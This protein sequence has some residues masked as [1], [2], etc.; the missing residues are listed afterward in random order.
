MESRTHTMNNLF[1]QL[2]E[3]C[4]E[5]AIA[6]FFETHGPLPSGMLLHEAGFWNSAQ[7]GFLREA[8][9]DDA[10]WAEVADRLNARLHAVA[11]LPGLRKGPG[12]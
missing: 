6:R 11:V 2:G 3:P 4:D 10:D 12:S 8:I 5:S 7:A 1:A 9:S